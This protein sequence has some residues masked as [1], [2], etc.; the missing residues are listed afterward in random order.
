TYDDTDAWPQPA[1]A[2]SPPAESMADPDQL[3]RNLYDP[4]HWADTARSAPTDPTPKLPPPTLPQPQRRSAVAGA[5][6]NLDIEVDAWSSDQAHA[7]R[8]AVLGPIHVRANGPEPERRRA[9][10]TEIAA[11]LA[12]HP[13][14]ATHDQLIDAVWPNGVHANAARGFIAT[15]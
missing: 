5:D 6:A 3:V 12:L 10:H 11:Y 1:P 15:V 14:G 2:T 8:I 13:L 4:E 9:L 7:P